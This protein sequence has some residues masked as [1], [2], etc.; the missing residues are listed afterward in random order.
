MNALS[1]TVHLVD[2]DVSFLA[3][4]SRFLRMSGFAVK[5]FSS[6]MNFLT[7]H[8][9]DASG[10]VVAE[11]QM[12]EMDGLCLQTALARTQ[13]PLPILFLTSRGDFPSS[14]QA[15]RGGAEDFLEKI[16]PKEKLLDAVNRCLVRDSQERMARVR[17]RK[18]RMLFDAL[19]GREHEVLEYVVQGKLNKQIAHDLRISERTIKHHRKSIT[20][21]LGVP[22]VA[23]ITRLTQ[24]AGI[25]TG[26]TPSL[27]KGQ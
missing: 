16:A 25:F 3:A 22:S 24:E 18:L 2:D 21:K 15:I 4:T 23:E 26:S 14:V 12:P 10:C 13:N 20:T 5:E 19:S 17:L 1:P 7:Q 9:L 27:T 8:D 6:A 11:L